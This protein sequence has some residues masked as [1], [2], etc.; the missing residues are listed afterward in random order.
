M[1]IYLICYSILVKSIAVR[2]STKCLSGKHLSYHIHLM[3]SMYRIDVQNNSRHLES[4]WA[5]PTHN[6]LSIQ[7]QPSVSVIVDDHWRMKRLLFWINSFFTA[8]QQYITDCCW[9]MRLGFKVGARSKFFHLESDW[10]IGRSFT[11]LKADQINHEIGGSSYS[12]QSY[13]DASCRKYQIC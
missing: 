9:H 5:A 6:T 3:I 11:L 7:C 10:A 13:H 4:D 1:S 8:S 12:V 2:A